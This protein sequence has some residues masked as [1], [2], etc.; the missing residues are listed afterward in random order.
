M[1]TGAHA[2]GPLIFQNTTVASFNASVTTHGGSS[3]AFAVNR[4]K[5]EVLDSRRILRDSR[6][7]GGRR[8]MRRWKQCGRRNYKQKKKK[9]SSL[10]YDACQ[11]LTAVF[12]AVIPVRYGRMAHKDRR[13]SLGARGY[14]YIARA[15]Y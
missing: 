5:S 8:G 9:K 12:V 1:W 6:L 13:Q 3:R 7:D 15:R 2:S 10:N 11:H 4:N 14:P